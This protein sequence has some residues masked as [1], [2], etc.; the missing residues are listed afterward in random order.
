MPY[1]AGDRVIVNMRD[2]SPELIP[3]SPWR[4]LAGTVIESPFPGLY[5]V[6]L[7]TPLEGHST[8]MDLGEDRLMPHPGT[9]EDPSL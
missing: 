7:D 8:L 5:H 2:L 6:R 1:Q 9:P 3:A 4:A